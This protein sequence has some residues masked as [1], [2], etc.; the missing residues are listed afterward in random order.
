M[1][2]IKPWL[3]NLLEQALIDYLEDSQ[4]SSSF[5][6]DPGDSNLIIWPLDPVD[7]EVTITGVGLL[8]IQQRRRVNMIAAGIPS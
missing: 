7:Y 8:H 5:G 4:Q 6:Y 1:C 3:K 2:S